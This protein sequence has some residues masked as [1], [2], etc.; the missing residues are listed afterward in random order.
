MHLNMGINCRIQKCIAFLMLTASFRVS[1]VMQNKLYVIYILLL[2]C[3]NEE[4][5]KTKNK[6]KSE[7]Q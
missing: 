5:K 4:P 1:G 6:H 2:L 7:P 3:F